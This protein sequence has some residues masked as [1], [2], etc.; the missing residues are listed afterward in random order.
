MGMDQ[1]TPNILMTRRRA[2]ACGAAGFAGLALNSHAG[3]LDSL[4]N[5]GGAEAPADVFKGDAPSE[6][7]W[8]LWCQR[9]WVKEA[10][11]YLKLDRN[12]QC[13]T[14]PNN[15]LLAPGDRS[16]CRNKVN[17]D[18]TLYTMVYGNPCTFHIDPV[19][20]KPLFHFLPGTP[21]FSLATS[22][23]V[24]RCLNCQNWEISQ[25][26]PEETKDPHGPAFRLRPPLP[27]GL[28]LQDM[29]RLSL[30][31]DDVVAVAQALQCPSISYTYSEPTAYYEYAYDTCRLAREQRLKN[32]IVTCGSIE[33]RPLRDLAQFVDAAHVDLK[34][35]S[36]AVYQKLNSGK[37]QPILDTLKTYHELG[38][39]F[40]V[41]NLIVPTYTDDLDMIKRMCG[42]LVANLGPDRPL[43]F[44]RFA[45]QHKLEH[46]PPTPVDILVR[47]RDAARAA[48]LHYVYIG[49]LRDVPDAGTTF[50]PN[51]RRAV[52]ERDVF[53]VTAYHLAAGKCRFCGTRIAGVWPA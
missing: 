32:I 43:H 20:K 26:K 49:N 14:C 22:G 1:T 16:H 28:S 51:C 50:C 12:V 6:E 19:E 42:W 13:K 2:L 41:I 44:S 25:K 11:H 15:C 10:S 45:P 37:L 24:F 52:V 4:L 30:F 23:C 9:G 46:L 5:F 35:F 29:S 33:D 7:L 39:W 18:G 27:S 31:P 38:V 48:G 34:G 8:A 53:S 36:D 17:R 21:T 3:W 40:E 47:A